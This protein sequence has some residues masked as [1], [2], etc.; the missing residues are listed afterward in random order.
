MPRCNPYGYATDAGPRHLMGGMYGPEYAGHDK[1]VRQDGIHGLGIC[2]QPATVRARMIC[3]E[4]HAGPVMDLCL[5]HVRTIRAR[6]SETC[7]RC[8]WPDAARGLDEAMNSTMR[9]MQ[10][11]GLR[12]DTLTLRR[13]GAHLDDL[14][15]EMDGLLARGV[16]AKRPLELVEIS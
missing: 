2:E 1:L 10:D 12:G 3:P 8:V 13:L 7:T 4:G 6:M 9:Q 16:I 15:Q 11:A 5:A 14:R